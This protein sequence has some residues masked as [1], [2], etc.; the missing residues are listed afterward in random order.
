MIL[1]IS[2][3]KCLFLSPTLRMYTVLR[4]LASVN[5][6]RLIAGRKHLSLVSVNTSNTFLPPIY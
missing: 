2:I 5:T 6:I 1:A 3:I 4:L